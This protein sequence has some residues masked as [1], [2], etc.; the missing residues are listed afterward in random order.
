MQMYVNYYDRYVK[1]SFE[2]PTIGILLCKEQ[3]EALVKRWHYRTMLFTLRNMHSICLINNYCKQNWTSGQK[4]FK[5]NHDEPS[6]P[7]VEGIDSFI[8][9]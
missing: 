7:S 1:Q 6:T 9:R 3:N 2:K 8:N 5:A 4:S